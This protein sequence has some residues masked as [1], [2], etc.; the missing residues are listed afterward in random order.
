[1][2]AHGVVAQDRMVRS[3]ARPLA[4]DLGPRIGIVY[5]DSLDP[6][7]RGGDHAPRAARLE[8]AEDLVFDLE[9]PAEVVFAGLQHRARRRRRVAA[10]LQLDTVE[11]RA[12]RA[13]VVAVQL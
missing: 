11:V 4:V 1:R 9:V 5:Q 3:R 10:A 13:L 7:A 8:P 12:S 6:A 2:L